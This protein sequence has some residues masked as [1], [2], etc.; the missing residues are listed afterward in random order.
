MLRD[1]EGDML[2]EGDCDGEIDG[3]M[4]GDFDS[5]SLAD[6]LGDSLGLKEPPEYSNVNTGR[7]AI[8]L[9]PQELR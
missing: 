7:R 1:I 6:M 8:L 4:D 3:E 5:D 9:F 2:I